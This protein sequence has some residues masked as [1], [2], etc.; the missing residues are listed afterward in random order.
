MF[1]KRL[2]AFFSIVP[3]AVYLTSNKTFFLML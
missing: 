1:R 2:E 3:L